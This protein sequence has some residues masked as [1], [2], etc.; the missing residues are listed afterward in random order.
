MDE[1]GIKYL[2]STE[3]DVP[4]VPAYAIDNFQA[5]Y[6]AGEWA[7]DNI[8]EPMGGIDELDLIVL[9][10]NPRGGELALQRSEGFGQAFADRYGF[11]IDD[12]IIVR[13]D[14][15]AGLAEDAKEAM[16]NILAANP[17]AEVI[18]LTTINEYTMEGAI[19]ALEAAG[20]WD[21]DKIIN[22][23]YGCDPVGQQQLRDGTVDGYI[24][25]FPE[26]YGHYAIPM[27]IGLVLGIEVPHT[28]YMKLEILTPDNIEDYYP[29]E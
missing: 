8:L 29:A 11:S 2:V 10:Q 28:Y 17:D 7:I 18:A 25:F 26:K 27:L 23:G 16:A 5:S 4:D 21:P 14:F 22:M 12:P 6:D 24:G 1:A 20:K 3:S 13:E 9:G 19:S 15:G